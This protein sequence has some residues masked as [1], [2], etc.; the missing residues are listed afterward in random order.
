MT[1]FVQR[2]LFWVAVVHKFDSTWNIE[3]VSKYKMKWIWNLN[4]YTSARS[5]HY[6][7]IWKYMLLSED[8]EISIISEV[9]KSVSQIRYQCFQN[10][11]YFVKAKSCSCLFFF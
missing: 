2:P 11:D 3:L 10:V 1:T 6:L 8:S 7:H 9:F 5:C 4:C